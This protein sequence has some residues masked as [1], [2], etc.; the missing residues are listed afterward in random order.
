MTASCQTQLEE[1]GFQSLIREMKVKWDKSRNNSNSLDKSE[2]VRDVCGINKRDPP[3]SCA[4]EP[5]NVLTTLADIPTLEPEEIAQQNRPS[6]IL[7]LIIT[8]HF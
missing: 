1:P 3:K 5:S 7:V 6:R 8:C 4:F 2:Q